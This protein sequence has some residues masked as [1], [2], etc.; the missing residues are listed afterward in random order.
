MVLE[1]IDQGRFAGIR[2]DGLE[3]HVAALGPAVK[4]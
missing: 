3:A 1:D 4:V 2:D